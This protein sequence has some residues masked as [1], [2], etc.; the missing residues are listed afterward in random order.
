MVFAMTFRQ[1]INHKATH[2][3]QI[4]LQL[5]IFYLDRYIS[6]NIRQILVAFMNNL[7][8]EICTYDRDHAL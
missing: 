4:L 2:L 8:V 5:F 7:L 3:V 6:L 1:K